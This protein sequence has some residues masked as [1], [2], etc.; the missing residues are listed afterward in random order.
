MGVVHAAFDTIRGE[1]I[2][3]KRLSSE[4]LTKHE[5]L[6]QTTVLFE[7]EYYNLSQLAHP[8]I[9]SPRAC[10]SALCEK[11]HITWIIQALSTSKDQ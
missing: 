4:R 5:G 6:E 7:R 2:A 8:H 9:S 10:R 1:E 11:T 3:L